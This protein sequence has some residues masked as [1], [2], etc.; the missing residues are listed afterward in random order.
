MPCSVVLILALQ[1]LVLV[2]NA[3]ILTLHRLGRGGVEGTGEEGGKGMAE[4]EG[5]KQAGEEAREGTG[6][7]TRREVSTKDI[8]RY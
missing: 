3:L 2:T 8:R 4:G 1:I 7:E 5:G 6:E